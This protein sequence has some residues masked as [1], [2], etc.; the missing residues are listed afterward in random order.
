MAD[1]RDAWSRDD[2]IRSLTSVAPA[3]TTAYRRDLDGFVQWAERAGVERPDQVTRTTL[4]RY[5]AYLATLRRAK[6]TVARKSSALRRYFSW[7]RRTGAIAADPTARLSTPK[8]DGRLPRVIP[9]DELHV[10][11]DDPP[12]RLEDDS[13]AVRARDDVVLELLYGSGLRVGELCQ[14][15]LGDIDVARGRAVVW[16]KGGKQRWVPLSGPAKGAVRRWVEH[17]RPEMV[18]DPAV[19][20]EALFVNGRG[21]PMTP[22]DVRRVLDRRAA[23]PTHP[24]ALRHTFATHLLDGGADLR[25]VQELLGH[26]DLATTQIYTHVSRE[27][28]RRVVDETHPRA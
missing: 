9:A 13:P 4:R 12:A 22:R 1:G 19:A 23:S 3:T 7:L 8:G 17:G 5:L 25:A 18:R 28:L 26:A 2:F 27:R 21:R 24:H 11:L 10:L 16:G 6:R 20:G 15:R 14:L